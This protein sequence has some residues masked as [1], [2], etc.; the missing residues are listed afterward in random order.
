MIV[1]VK[2]Y[3]SGERFFQ[4][5]ALSLAIH[6]AMLGAII[7]NSLWERRPPSIRPGVIEITPVIP[8]RAMEKK[9]EPAK[10]LKVK[11]PVM[12]AT[13]KVKSRTKVVPKG[14]KIKPEKKLEPPKPPKPPEPEKRIKPPD[15]QPPKSQSFRAEGEEFKYQYYVK[16]VQRKVDENWVTHGLD[17]VGQRSDPQVYFRI[18][19]N[20][21]VIDA[22][23]EKS[24]GSLALDQSA[25]EAVMGTN[26][27]PL[28]AGYRRDYLGVYYDFDYAQKD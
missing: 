23:L 9:P 28:P 16:I 13:K 24:S 18:G 22:R 10:P 6:T 11:K 21:Q 19:K 25:L 7:I 27:P 15:R 20:G 3:D 1:R 8:R 2:D 12:R 26:F 17:T 4:A 14:S 5:I